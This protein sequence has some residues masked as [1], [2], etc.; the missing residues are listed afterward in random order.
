ML[1]SYLTLQIFFRITLEAWADSSM[2]FQLV[3]INTRQRMVS[4]TLQTSLLDVVFTNML[5]VNVNLTYSHLSDHSQVSV[6]LPCIP[7]P[8]GKHTVDFLDWSNYSAH[9]IRQLFSFHFKGIN[10]LI[11]DPDQ[12]NNRITTA[13][14]QSLNVLLPKRSVTLRNSAQ[15][16]SPKII[17]LRNKKS[18]AFKS[19]TRNKTADT[20]EKLKTA[21]LSLIREVKK[22]KQ[23]RIWSS[24]CKDSRSFWATIGTLMGKENT[25]T[26]DSLF[27]G[28][29]EI[30]DPTLIANVFSEHFNKKI[31]DLY[32]TCA[33][34]N[35]IVPDL[36]SDAEHGLFITEDELIEAFSHLKPSKA[37]GFDELPSKVIRHLAPVIL[38]PFYGYSTLSFRLLRFLK[39]G[40]SL[41]LSL[42][43]R[44]EI[45]KMLLITGPLVI[46]RV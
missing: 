13:I 1:I 11:K 36:S 18:K 6:T 30:V 34:E 35:F 9:A 25:Q 19:W 41:E 15:V 14:C 8:R 5:N 43:T 29:N 37:Q 12:I 4:E 7:H 31:M 28:Q 45:R 33:C 2:L 3:D 22:Q 46:Y 32:V 39:H 20:H 27:V 24:L 10:I 42:F 44:K 21:S 38:H 16:L 23:L 17:N 40:K 26:Q